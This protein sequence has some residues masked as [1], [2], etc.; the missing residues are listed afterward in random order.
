MGKLVLAGLLVLAATA[1]SW[2]QGFNPGTVVGNVFQD[3]ASGCGCGY[4]HGCCPPQSF[5]PARDLR[6]YPYNRHKRLVR[7]SAAPA[8]SAAH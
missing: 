1:V 6:A 7:H 5:A 8:T 4:G 2:A 3:P